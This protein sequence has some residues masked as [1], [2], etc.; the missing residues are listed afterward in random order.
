ME[1]VPAPRYL[2]RYY[3]GWY[4]VMK[5]D[6][7]RPAYGA[8]YHAYQTQDRFREERDALRRLRELNNEERFAKR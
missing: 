2:V 1:G 4:L 6:D 3:E 5:R 7:S 8:H